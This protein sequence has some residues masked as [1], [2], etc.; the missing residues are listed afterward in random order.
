MG[1]TVVCQYLDTAL[2]I[3]APRD[4]A[5]VTLAGEVIDEFGQISGGREP[6]SGLMQSEIQCNQDNPEFNSTFEEIAS[7]EED[8]LK[9]SVDAS[10]VKKAINVEIDIH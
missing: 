2:F 5:V 1:N 9:N 6:L 4:F 8:L 10:S 3:D 7:I